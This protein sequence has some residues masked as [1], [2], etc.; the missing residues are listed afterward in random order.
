MDNEKTPRPEAGGGQTDAP[1]CEHIQ[2]HPEVVARVRAA[3]PDTE[4]QMRLSD[5][6]RMFGDPTRIRILCALDV[7]ELCVCDLAQLVGLS[8]SAVSHQLRLLKAAGLVTYRREGK[9]VIYA[10]ADAH[11]RTIIECGAEHIRE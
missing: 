11:V 10:P 6:F 4:E 3:M 2:V 9:N 1:G 5:L 8:V 7:S